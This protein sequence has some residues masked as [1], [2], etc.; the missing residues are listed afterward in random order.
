MLI[1]IL[2]DTHDD[3]PRLVRAMAMIDTLQPQA[4]IHCG[5]LCSPDMLAPLA[6]R[7]A[8]FVFGNNDFA[9]DELRAEAKR[10]NITCLDHCGQLTLAGKTIIV[11][12]GHDHRA[13][14]RVLMANVDYLFSGHTHLQHDS[15]QRSTRMINPGA[16]FRARE[17]TFATVDLVKDT[18]TVHIVA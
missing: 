6:N 12:H 13:R 11:M 16:L 4:I 14:D 3:M 18:V 9:H 2:S 17:K 15:R 7:N 5:D 10:L 8:Y 1:A